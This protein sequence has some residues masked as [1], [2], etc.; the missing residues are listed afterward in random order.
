MIRNPRRAPHLNQRPSADMPEG[1]WAAADL[2]L[3]AIWYRTLS[4]MPTAC[5]FPVSGD[6]QPSKE[7]SR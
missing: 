2:T 4:T 1:G 6:Q 3:P 5:E 7:T